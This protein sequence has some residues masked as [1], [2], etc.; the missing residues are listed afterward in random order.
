MK[1]SQTLSPQQAIKAISPR[2]V[3]AV[4]FRFEALGAGVAFVK[5]AKVHARDALR[6]LIPGARV[7]F[8]AIDGGT[9]LISGPLRDGDAGDD[10]DE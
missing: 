8:S 7:H 1:P 2:D 6:Q 4:M 5:T 10:D 3:T 9:V